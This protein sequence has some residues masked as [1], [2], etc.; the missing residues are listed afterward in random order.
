MDNKELELAYQELLDSNDELIFNSVSDDGIVDMSSLDK[1]LSSYN[2][3]VSEIL[4]DI[5]SFVKKYAEIPS[6]EMAGVLGYAYGENI[7]ASDVDK[8]RSEATA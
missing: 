3:S 2:F 8:V 5:V 6:S 7:S 4:N 1:N